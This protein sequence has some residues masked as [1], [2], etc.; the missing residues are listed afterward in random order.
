MGK[1]IPN[2]NNKKAR[3]AILMSSHMFLGKQTAMCP[4]QTPHS[5]KGTVAMRGNAP[6]LRKNRLKDF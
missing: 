2:G 6:I 4:R 1:D 5:S 3:A